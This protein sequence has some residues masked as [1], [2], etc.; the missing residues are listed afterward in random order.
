MIFNNKGNTFLISILLFATIIIVFLFI[1]AVYF[2]ITNSM[3]YNIKLNMYS[4]NRAALISVNK[5]VTSRHGFD[6]NAKKLRESFEN[7][8][9]VNYNLDDNLESKNGLVQKVEIVEYAILE[10]GRYDSVTRKKC[11][12]NVIHSII[13]VQIKPLILQDQFK[14]TY[15]YEIHEDVALNKLVVPRNIWEN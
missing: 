7:L 10:P 13:K 4:L 8:I 9:K 6:Y 12:D 1:C 2:G 14:E 3:I 5:G 11:Q 15:T